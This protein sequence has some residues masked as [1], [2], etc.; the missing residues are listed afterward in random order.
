[1]PIIKDVLVKKTVFS[2]MQNPENVK[3]YLDATKKMSSSSVLNK[4][5]NISSASDDL[6][7]YPLKLN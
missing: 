5:P 2:T 1:M 6:R 7:N 3:I 4:N